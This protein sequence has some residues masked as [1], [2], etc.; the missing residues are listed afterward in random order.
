[1]ALTGGDVCTAIITKGIGNLPACESMITSQLSIAG[2]CTV[3]V[4]PGRNTGGSYPLAP[5]EI[6]NLYQ[7][8]DP[9]PGFEN[10]PAFLVPDDQRDP[11]AVR[12]Q[13]LL[14]VKFNNAETE[15]EF[16]VSPR[17]AAMAIRVINFINKT[18]DRASV[19]FK[20]FK[21]IVNKSVQI[22]NFRKKR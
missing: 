7:P 6:G 17:R 14:K 2:L 15:R 8:V 3:T 10:H 22:L 18:A 21:R 11:F 1:M 5:G 12:Q 20:G 19:I 4:L 16:L 13:V 9:P